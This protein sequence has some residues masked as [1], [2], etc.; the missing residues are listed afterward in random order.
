MSG[1]EKREVRHIVPILQTSMALCE[2]MLEK[3]RVQRASPAFLGKL[4]RVLV[5][6]NN[7]RVMHI[8]YYNTKARCLIRLVHAP[9][10]RRWQYFWNV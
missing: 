4:Q 5:Y 8:Q 7:F 10:S 9:L 2:E 6:Q 1:K 3:N